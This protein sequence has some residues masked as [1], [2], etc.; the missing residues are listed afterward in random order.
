MYRPKQPLNRDSK[1]DFYWEMIMRKCDFVV[2]F[3]R[4]TELTNQSNH[5]NLT[6]KER[7][8]KLGVILS[9]VG[10][11]LITDFMARFG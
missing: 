6:P 5:S 3:D 7:F 4:V 9:K 8:E 1:G 2:L 10:Y 11:Q